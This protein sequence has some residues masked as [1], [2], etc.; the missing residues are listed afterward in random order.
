MKTRLVYILLVTFKFKIVLIVLLHQGI[1]WIFGGFSMT[2]GNPLNDIR[3]FDTKVG[4]WLPVTIQHD[5]ASP[6]A[7]PPGDIFNYFIQA[8]LC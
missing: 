6:P 8:F 2:T 1:L 5:D 4:S 3:A 7:L